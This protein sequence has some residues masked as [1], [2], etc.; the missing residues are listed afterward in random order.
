MN[1][2][3][4][5]AIVSNPPFPIMKE[6]YRKGVV[7]DDEA[8][9]LTAFLKHA[10]KEQYFQHPRDYQGRFL[11]SGVGGVIILLIIYSIIWRQRRKKIVNHDIFKRQ[12]RS[13]SSLY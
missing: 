11:Y 12:V 4:I 1:E 8:F 10:D 5:K 9:Y 13:E 6:A 3:G 2:A 7:S